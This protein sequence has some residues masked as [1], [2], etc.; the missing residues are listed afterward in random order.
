VCCELIIDCSDEVDFDDADI[1]AMLNR[2]S[3]NVKQSLEKGIKH[4]TAC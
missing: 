2:S 4:V 3:E 1:K